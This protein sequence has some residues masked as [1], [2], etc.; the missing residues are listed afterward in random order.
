MSLPNTISLKI[1]TLDYFLKWFLPV[2]SEKCA[3]RILSFSTIILF[4]FHSFHSWFASVSLHFS[5]GTVHLIDNRK[6]YLMATFKN[7]RFL[8]LTWTNIDKIAFRWAWIVLC[9]RWVEVL[10]FGAIIIKV[11]TMPM[12]HIINAPQTTRLQISTINLKYG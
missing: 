5:L 8:F 11:W 6:C 9:E 12:L 4:Y 2:S 10:E 3:S 7:E 1:D